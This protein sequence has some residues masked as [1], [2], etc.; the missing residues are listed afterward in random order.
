M[1]AL[2]GR[3]TS[4]CRPQPWP[5]QQLKA[6]AWAAADGDQ[7]GGKASFYG[8][9][10]GQVNVRTQA[11]SSLAPKTS[12]MRASK[13]GRAGLSQQ[14]SASEACVPEMQGHLLAALQGRST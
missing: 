2:Q 6:D 7:Q 8:R 14:V 11:A 3:S 1:A 12:G 5:S 10:A 4:G 13:A 9:P